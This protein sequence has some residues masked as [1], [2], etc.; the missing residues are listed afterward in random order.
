MT[1]NGTHHPIPT[2]PAATPAERPTFRRLVVEVVETDTGGREWVLETVEPDEKDYAAAGYMR[3]EQASELMTALAKDGQGQVVAMAQA[4]AAVSGAPLW[5][6]KREEVVGT[7][8]S[9][10]AV[11]MAEPPAFAQG[12]SS[13]RTICEK[14]LGTPGFICALPVGHA[15]EGQCGTKEEPVRMV[16]AERAEVEVAG[17]LPSERIVELHGALQGHE[18][19]PGSIAGRCGW[20]VALVAMYLDERLGRGGT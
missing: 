4:L 12:T 13:I 5:S 16:G 17:K 19:E 15:P 3:A 1:T 10:E 14:A 7:T 9:G 2:S 20:Q 8:P 18:I 11:R 6:T